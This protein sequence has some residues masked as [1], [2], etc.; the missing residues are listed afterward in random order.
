M[1]RALA[2]PLLFVATTAFADRAIVIGRVGDGP[3]TDAPTLARSDQKAQLS[4]VVVRHHQG[5]TPE[6]VSHVFIENKLVELSPLVGAKLHWSTVEPH[7]FRAQPAANGATSDFYSNVSTEPKTFG[8]WLGYDHVDYFE[9]RAANDEPI[10]AATVAPRDPMR[11]ARWRASARLRYKVEV[12]CRRACTRRRARAPTRSIRRD[13]AAVHRVSIRAR[14]RLSR[15]ADRVLQVPEVFGSAGHGTNHQTEQVHRRRLRR[16][17]GRRDCAAPATTWRTRTSRAAAYATR[18]A[19]GDR[20]RRQ[21]HAGYQITGVQRGR[22][23]P[24][25][26]RRRVAHHTPRDLDHVAALWEDRSDPHGP[27]QGAPTASSTAVTS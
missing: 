9:R 16:R 25:R 6:G 15:A 14:R 2:I 26:L 27:L 7:G 19:G 21:R 1:T 5:F 4:V 20:A 3:W 17:D 23:H 8:R 12:V 10:I 13:F 24:D 11:A 18:V 22:P